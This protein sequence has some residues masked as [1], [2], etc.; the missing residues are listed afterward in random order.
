MVVLETLPGEDTVTQVY[1]TDADGPLNNQVRYSIVETIYYP[2]NRD[3]YPMR[4][5]FAINPSSGVITSN[6]P[7]YED[8]AQGY[9][10]ITVAAFDVKN[11]LLNDTMTVTVRFTGLRHFNFSC[12]DLI[13][14]L[15]VI[16]FG[17]LFFFLR[18][19]SDLSFFQLDLG[20]FLGHHQVCDPYK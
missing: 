5:A 10:E 20:I 13:N 6:L 2:P 7:S 8:F 19:S 1:A 15:Y 3:P 12:L 4:G 18:V 11:Q 17:R 14:V 9:Y 16:G